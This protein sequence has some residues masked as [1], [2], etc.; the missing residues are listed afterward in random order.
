MGESG[1]GKT[2]VL[3]AIPRLL[4][5]GTVVG[6]EI[7][8]ERGGAKLNV[9]ELSDSELSKWR[10]RRVA[11]VPQ[12]AM[13]SFT[14]HLTIERHIT[15][16]LSYHLTLNSKERAQRARELLA[17][18]GLGASFLSRYPHELSG[19]QKQ[20]AALSVALS[21]EPDFLLADEPTTA[22]D[23]ITQKETLEMMT[24]IARTRGMGLLLVTH[25]LP[26][27][28][29]FC[30]SLMVM[31]DG[32]VVESGPSKDLCL[33]PKDGYT[34]KLIEAIREMS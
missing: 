10:W 4:P 17:S 27:A 9:A 1:S 16:T 7:I 25:D 8:Y 28:A 12:G 18:V 31:K 32:I 14:P 29:A 26:L 11:L 20:R 3:M 34:K 24:G 19:G 21:C 2:S 13:N 23:V 15:E 33:R 5:A 30:D 22:L 6:G